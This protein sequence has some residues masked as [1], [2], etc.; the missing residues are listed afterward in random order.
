MLIRTKFN[1][2]AADGTRRMPFDLGSSQPA[3]DYTPVANASSEAAQLG[4]QLGQDQLAETRRQYDQNYSVIKP[5]V[6]AQTGI[7]EDARAQGKDYYDYSKKFR[8]LE[9]DMLQIAS[10]WQA[11]LDADKTERDKIEALTSG[12]ALELQQRTNDFG[13]KQAADIGLYTGGNS[14]IADRYSAD[15]DKDVGTAIA[16]ARAGQ[17]QAQ[18]SAIRQAMRYGFSVPAA[19]S[20]VGTAGASAIAAAANNTRDK[21]ISNYRQLVGE[22]IGLRGDNFKTTQTATADAMNRSEG[23][24][25]TQRN[26]RIQDEAIKWG[27]ALDVTG[28]GRGLVGASQGSYGVA[29]GAGSAAAQAQLGTSGQLLQGLNQSAQTQLQGKQLQMQGLSSILGSQTNLANTGGNDLGKI[30][31]GALGAWASTGFAWSDRRLKRDVCRIGTSRAGH[32][33]YSYRYLWSPRR[34]VGVMADEVAHVSGA[35]RR[36]G[37]VS[38]VNYACL[39]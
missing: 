5:I 39:H 8:P 1:G 34:H 17:A 20:G 23:A 38:M 12:H 3:P 27:R 26:Q 14:G 33:I 29:T 21:S 19:L 2:Y 9:Q 32:A 31:G 13:A 36:I 37:G 28:L 10:N 30:V 6:D 22:G 25:T 35:V 11:Q 18:N 4:A 24:L 7:M 16:D 15:I